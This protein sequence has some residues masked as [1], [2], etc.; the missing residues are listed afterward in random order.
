M[1]F[2]CVICVLALSLCAEPLYDDENCETIGWQSE[3]ASGI[4]GIECFYSNQTILQTYKKF[5]SD[6][7]E[8]QP[9]GIY[10]KL[11]AKLESG[12]NYTYE[13]EDE[14]GIIIEYKYK[15]DNNKTLIIDIFRFGAP[16]V[17]YQFTQTDDGTRLSVTF[18]EP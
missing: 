9:N 3:E 4:L 7:I 11:R 5:R 15:W 6:E 14:D 16:C 8:A 18:Y 17:S 1:K 12:K 2:L 10:K 13:Y